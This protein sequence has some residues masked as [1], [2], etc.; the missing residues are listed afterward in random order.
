[1][2]DRELR[3]L[4]DANRHDEVL[5]SIINRLIRSRRNGQVAVAN[6]LE[7]TVIRRM[8]LPLT[9]VSPS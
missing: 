2:T 3:D 5:V 1:M 9:V 6:R 4:R 8:G 7:A